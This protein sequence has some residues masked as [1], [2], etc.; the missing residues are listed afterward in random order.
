MIIKASVERA[1]RKRIFSKSANI[2][3]KRVTVRTPE[4]QR[5]L[6]AL[7]ATQLTRFVRSE[8]SG[9]DEMMAF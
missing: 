6:D 7:I 3:E 4:D 2:T 1:R 9:A 5:E 8:L